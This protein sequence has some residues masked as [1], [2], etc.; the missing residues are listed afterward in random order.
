MHVRFLSVATRV[1]GALSWFARLAHTRFAA[2]LARAS[3]FAVGLVVLACVG[4]AAGARPTSGAALAAPAGP[5]AA[6]DAGT[7]RVADAPKSSGA[8]PAEGAPGAAH[9]QREAPADLPAPTGRC[10]NEARGRATVEDPVVLNLATTDD[11]HRLPGVG[12][13]RALAIVALR[14]KLGHFRRV[15]D[16]LRVRGIGRAT[17]RRLRPLLRVDASPA[18]PATPAASP[19]PG[20]ASGASAPSPR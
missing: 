18:S 8:A 12:E 11:L 2:P 10:T 5:D 1:R 14:E 9:A 15:E 20:A 16:L 19:K 13:K 17:L 3:L 7:V 6:H 4:D